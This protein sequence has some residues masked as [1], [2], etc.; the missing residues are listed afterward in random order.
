MRPG[1]LAV[2]LEAI[3]RRSPNDLHALETLA[4]HVLDRLEAGKTTDPTAYVWKCDQSRPV[5]KAG[6]PKSKKGGA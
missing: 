4:D 5:W 2:K 3:G 6:D 1:T